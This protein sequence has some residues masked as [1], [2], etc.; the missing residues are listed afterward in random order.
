MKIL[1]ILK[2]T[3]YLRHFD[4]AV[5]FLASRG[6]QVRLASQDSSLEL[7]SALRNV[8]GVSITACPKKRGDAWANDASLFR[9]AEDYLRY[10]E[11]PYDVATKL[12]SRAFSKLVQTLSNGQRDADLAWS[13]VGLEL[14]DV[15]IR[16]LRKFFALVEETLPSDSAIE[17]FLKQESPDAVVITPLIDIGS[18]QTDFVKSARSLGIPVGMVLF[19][20]DN[21]STKGCVHVM[22]DRM[23]VWNELQ[24]REAIELHGVPEQRVSVT[25]A[26]RFDRFID[27]AAGQGSVTTRS[28]FCRPL[29]F[30]KDKPIILYLASSKFVAGDER[31]FI[32]DWI[33]DV[34]TSEDPVVAGANLLIKTHP[35]LNRDWS[36]G[37]EERVS[38]PGVEP[39]LVSSPFEG[40]GGFPSKRVA[41]IRN[42]FTA[43][44]S[45]YECLYHS[46]VVVGL[47]TSAEL[48]AAILGKPVLT[49]AAGGDIQAGQQETLHFHY[50]LRANGGFVEMAS[51]VDEHLKQLSDVVGGRYD[52][53]HIQSFVTA[54]LRP[55]GWDINSS[56]VLARS[57]V[58]GLAPVKVRNES[59]KKSQPAHNNP[60]TSLES[61]VAELDY[62]QHRIL[63]KASTQMERRW[64]ARACAKE[65]WTVA[66]LEESVRQGDVFYDIGANIGAFSLIAAMHCAKNLQ[67]IAFEPGY[68][69]FA[70][71]CDNIVLNGCESVITPLPLPLSDKTE[72]AKF[73]YRSREAGQ[74][75]HSLSEWREE[76]Q[77]DSLRRY[78]QPVLAM[79]LDEMV[80]TFN[81]PYPTH[82]KIDVDGGELQV[83]NGATGVL[84]HEDLQTLLVEI[85]E[86][87]GHDVVGLLSDAGF[88][89]VSRHQHA[90][91]VNAPWYGL[92]KRVVGPGAVLSA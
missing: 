48:E 37:S 81:L 33:R 1:F 49:L 29:G 19:S 50:L 62:S 18:G 85:D 12:R 40:A 16:R 63:I 56:K 91:K 88:N 71:L 78:R 53:Q 51:S 83:L 66:W 7:P 5:E 24:K 86:E 35:D 2:Q 25:G 64:R 10:L 38:W 67:V 60:S 34:R 3:G 58:K 17:K 79:R 52:S 8:T 90:G 27:L 21:L 44:Q 22:P 70:H 6:H 77:K 54:F 45:L 11:P 14:T 9:R 82:L 92:F 42:R 69:S 36:D 59:D 84:S 32:Q 73:K 30:K 23:F 87:L 55:R 72:L 46:T 15:E 75:R 89:L 80:K 31:P 47:N 39:V 57:I 61:S 26:P 20:W 4:T 28:D 13:E 43:A 74:S 76:A 65:P 68:A 41:V